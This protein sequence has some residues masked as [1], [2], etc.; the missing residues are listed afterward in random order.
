MYWSCVSFAL[1]E[2]SI[3]T[4]YSQLWYIPKNMD[5]AHAF[6]YFQVWLW[7]VSSIDCHNAGE[8]GRLQINGLVQDR[9]NSIAN[10]LELL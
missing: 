4:L 1:I 5:I 8:A 7:P 6:L 3:S 10:A 2:L 9:S